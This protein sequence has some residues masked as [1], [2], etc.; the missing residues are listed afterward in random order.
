M[1]SHSPRKNQQSKVVTKSLHPRNLH[2][3]GYDF[4]ALVASYSSLASY[5]KK[6]DYGKLSIDFSEPVAVKTLNSALLK[7]HYAIDNW[8]IPE[9]ALCP[10]IP[11][12]VDYIHYIADLLKIELPVTTGRSTKPTISLLDIGTGANGIYPLLASQVYGWQCVGSDINQTSLDNV[13]EI[14]SKNKSLTDRFTLRLQTD[15]NHI[16]A[17]IIQDGDYF[18]VTVCNPPFHSSLEEAQKGSQ[19]KLTNLARNRGEQHSQHSSKSTKLNFGGAGAELWC[20]GGERLFIKK[21]INESKTFA[22]QCHWFTTLVSKSDNLKPS[23][24]LLQKIGATDI[25]EIEMSQGNKI[26]RILAWTFS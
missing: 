10:P 25:R 5:V 6:N 23:R 3:H 13:A 9:G 8:D 4:P 22:K 16:F 26:T 12:R 1:T 18:D 11:G 7:H 21:M 15:K 2:R 24:K 20:N 17:G 14:I 19:R